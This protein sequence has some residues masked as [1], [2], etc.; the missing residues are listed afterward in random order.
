M[1]T[2]VP[3]QADGAHSADGDASPKL[4]RGG[5]DAGLM[6]SA[7]SIANQ[8]WQRNAEEDVAASVG[9]GAC[10]VGAPSSAPSAKRAPKRGRLYAWGSGDYGRLGHGDTLPQR[11]AKLVE[12]LRDKDVCKVVCGLRH[13]LVLTDSGQVYSYGFGG[14][15]Q[16]G[17]GDREIQTLPTLVQALSGENIVEI[18][19]GDKHSV[20]LT[21]GGDVFT[22]GEG[23]LGQLGLGAKLQRH[24]RP[25]RIPELLTQRIVSISA[26]SSHTGCVDDEGNVYMWGEGQ[27]GRLGLED[28]HNVSTPTLV[29][30]LSG[31]GIESIVCFNEHTFAL[32]VSQGGG[33]GGGRGGSLAADAAAETT[34]ARRSKELEVRL[35][36][37]QSRQ[38]SAEQARPR[39]PFVAPHFS[40]PIC[41]AP[42]FALHTSLFT[43]RFPHMPDPLFLHV[44]PDSCVR[45]E[46]KL[47]ASRSAFLDMERR[48]ERL[49]RQNEALLQERVDLYLKVQNLESALGVASSDK[50]N[51]DKQLASLINIPSSLSE[52][53]SH[54]VKQVACGAGHVLALSDTG[55]VY[56]WGAGGAGQLG[57]GR[58]NGHS[59]PQLVWGMA[60][61]GVRQI[62][63][64]GRHSA[65]LTYNG[66]LFTWGSSSSGQLGHGD[67]K[68]QLQPKLV[69]T[70]DAEA[71]ERSAT[72]RLVGCGVRHTAA[73]LSSGD[74]FMWGK[75]AFGRLGRA[76]LDVQTEPVL[77]EALW[78]RDI[79]ENETD[80]SCAL[81]KEEIKELLD[82]KLGAEEIVRYYP[83]IE[84]D[85]EAAL[86]LAK[87]VADELKDKVGRLEI[88]LQGARNDAEHALER[89]VA[90]QEK[91]FALATQKNVEE[92]ETRHK[93][94]GEEVEVLQ[95][96]IDYQGARA[97]A[98]HGEIAEVQLQIDEASERME[99]SISQVKIHERGALARSMREAL[100]SLVAARHDKQMQL[101][102]A[103]AQ[104]KESIERINQTRN[105]LASVNLEL[106]QNE[107][108]G[109]QRS[110]E[111]FKTIVAEVSALSQRLNATAVE[112]VSTDAHE[113]P[114]DDAGLR[115]LIVRSNEEIDRIAMQAI[116]FASD[117]HVDAEV[118]QQLAQ[119]L[120][121]NAQMR[122]QLNVYMEGILMQAVERFDQPCDEDPSAG[123]RQKSQLVGP[124]GT[125]GTAMRPQDD[126]G[127]NAILR[128]TGPKANQPA[129]DKQKLGERVVS[130]QRGNSRHR[131]ADENNA[132]RV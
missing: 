103:S 60:R 17:H 90:D 30:S 104:E 109:Y 20:A 122:K 83:D 97:E 70:L 51:L 7:L 4:T 124:A 27:S 67:K 75:P 106:K 113:A 72:V 118:R 73:V 116:A 18:A 81:G 130:R 99:G 112:H 127:P 52:I 82:Q 78:R 55:D 79:G 21:A 74:L 76:K 123:A 63:A 19:C 69:E 107:K 12:M 100:E 43:P 114:R 62:G 71:R 95:R 25:S 119:L 56:S 91:T 111:R 28:E 86:F 125:A 98:L 84:S 85:K 15:G 23:A 57:L 50:G 31:R 77:Y 5:F 132:L 121:D 87:A 16:L 120:V 10:T 131:N 92:L 14:D 80:R 29:K 39:T 42:F 49:E 37:A 9:A 129:R 59:S 54:G 89:F 115:S 33:Y 93:M 105:E 40:R 6:S 32:T 35:R 68:S 41:R 8:M 126:T 128:L 96:S 34:L 117:E 53:S 2:V 64:A 94:L 110:I 22:W 13:T 46:Q 65:A 61:K 26:G 101:E 88:E 102:A 45:D 66:Y 48:L 44:S 24:L 38:E 108:H 36:K 1:L 47:D 11:S 58:R 3:N